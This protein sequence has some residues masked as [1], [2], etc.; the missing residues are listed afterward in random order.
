MTLLYLCYY[1]HYVLALSHKSVVSINILA[2]SG[3]QGTTQSFTNI[4]ACYLLQLS[5]CWPS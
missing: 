1:L 5:T 3:V 2:V 4:H